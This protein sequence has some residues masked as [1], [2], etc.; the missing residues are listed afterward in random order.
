MAASFLW[1]V[2]ITS[3]PQHGYCRLQITKAIQIISVIDDVY[4]VYGTLDELELFTDVI[5]RFVF[6]ISVFC[7]LTEY[8]LIT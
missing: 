4:D 2:G 6:F 3:E 5:E 7:L 8:I 1:S